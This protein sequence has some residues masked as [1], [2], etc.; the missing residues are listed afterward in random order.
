MK[1]HQFLL[2]FLSIFSIYSY[3]AS[4]DCSKASTKIEKTICSNNQLSTLDNE[5]SKYFINLKSQLDH[6]DFK[7]LL[8][9]QRK[10]IKDRNRTCE[11]R[12]GMERCLTSTYEN[13]INTLDFF[14]T[15][16]IPSL[17]DL[18]AV[19]SGEGKRTPVN[20]AL[21]DINND[22][23]NEIAIKTLE[24]TMRIPGMVFKDTD[25]K[26]INIKTIGFEWSTYWTYHSSYFEYNGR[27]YNLHKKDKGPSHIRY[28]TADN[29]S[30]VVCEFEN[31]ESEKFTPTNNSLLSSKICALASKKSLKYVTLKG[32]P[33]LTPRQVRDAG[34][35]ETQIEQQGYVDINNDGKN[36]LV[37][38]FI[39]ASGAGRGCGFSY[40]DELNIKDGSFKNIKKQSPLLKMQ[41]MNLEFG[42]SNC[43]GMNN[44]LFEHD[45]KIYYEINTPREHRISIL[46]GSQI[47]NICDI[48]RSTETSV[49][50]IGPPQ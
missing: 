36:E 28:T 35:R 20:E 29:N 43:G 38:R 3:A 5:L 50:Y 26:R 47:R 17:T 23:E 1:Y 21:F 14:S 18:D 37:A 25:G 45:E 19:C 9:E 33:Q 39:Y 4:F 8:R 12:R 2:T 32:K 30:Y 49:R 13:R 7:I 10:W 48:Q 31:N 27:V 24:G 34:R 6:K 41:G 40:Y 42:R 11:N 46:E 44:N 22:G 16:N 15:K